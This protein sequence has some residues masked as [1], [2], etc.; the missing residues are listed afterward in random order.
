M[1]ARRPPPLC[2]ALIS[3]CC[4]APA[5]GGPSVDT[6]RAIAND[7]RRLT[8]FDDLYPRL[9]ANTSAAETVAVVPA[10]PLPAKESPQ[11]SKSRDTEAQFGLSPAQLQAAMRPDKQR[12]LADGV[13]AS[14]S[15]IARGPDYKF[16]VSLDN[17][18][19]WRQIEVDSLAWPRPGEPVTIRHGVLGS[20]MLV[21][22]QGAASHVR[23]VK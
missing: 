12:V 13:S 17:G 7:T 22:A 6:C 4:T 16:V 15:G 23:R 8:C 14:V 19:V 3:V 21:T 20:F 9:P 1:D 10:P 5:V 18:Q 2:V 11:Q